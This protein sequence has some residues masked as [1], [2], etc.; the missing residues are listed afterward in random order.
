MHDFIE[1]GMDSGVLDVDRDGRTTALG[2]GLMVI[3]RLFGPAF[4][5]EALISKAISP[6]SPYYGE[7]NAW[8]LVAA[9][10]CLHTP[11]YSKPNYIL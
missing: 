2:D 6:E 9:N 4:A 11:D 5:G 7:D 10:R 1:L 8:E 3:R